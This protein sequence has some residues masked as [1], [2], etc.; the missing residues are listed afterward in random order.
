MV[1]LD[2]QF[3]VSPCLGSWS[4]SLIL[5]VPIKSGNKKKKE[6]NNPKVLTTKICMMIGFPSGGMKGL[7]GGGGGGRITKSLE[8]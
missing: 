5:S 4:D 6:I 7:S 2:V 3:D 8:T 1:F